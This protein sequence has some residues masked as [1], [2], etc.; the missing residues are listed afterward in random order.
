M[1]LTSL[2]E[3]VILWTGGLQV[4]NGNLS[5]G[6]LITFNAL[7][8]YYYDPIKNLVSLQPQLQEAFVASDR[9]GEILDLKPEKNKEDNKIKVSKLKGNIRLKNINFK[10]DKITFKGNKVKDWEYK[11][12]ENELTLKI[13]AEEGNIVIM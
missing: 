3:V 7:L 1:A 10:P 8:A 4:I 9:L 13:K 11:L 5:L 2:S 6:Q 12:K